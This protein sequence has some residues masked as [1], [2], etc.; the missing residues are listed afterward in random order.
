LD[1]NSEPKPLPPLQVVG[2]LHDGYLFTEMAI[3]LEEVSAMVRAT[4]RA[5]AITVKIAVK[6][7]PHQ[8]RAVTYESVINRTLPAAAPRG[9]VLYIDENGLHASDPLQAGLPF[10]RVESAPPAV[11]RTSVEPELAA[12]GAD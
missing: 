1:A 6:K 3:A 2:R 9:A 12:G 4:G 11:T 10:T 8:E 5:G 7:T